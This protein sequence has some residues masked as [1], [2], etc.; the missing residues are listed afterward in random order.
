MSAT[1]VCAKSLD[2]EGYSTTALALGVE[3]G[4]AFCKTIP[5]I[6]NAFFIDSS[7]NLHVLYGSN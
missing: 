4:L 6:E 2:A 3:A 5:E 7:G 1:L